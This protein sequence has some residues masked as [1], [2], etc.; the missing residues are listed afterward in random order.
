MAVQYIQ[1]RVTNPGKPSRNS[2]EESA[3]MSYGRPRR[4]LSGRLRNSSRPSSLRR[5]NGRKKAA[6]AVVVPAKRKPGRPKKVALSPAAVAVIEAPKKRK[7]RK[8]RKKAGLLARAK[9]GASRFGRSLRSLVLGAPKK[10]RKGG[11]KGKASRK[12]NP[13]HA[14]RRNALRRVRRSN[15]GFDVKS[16]LIESAVLVGGTIAAIYAVPFIESKLKEL[17]PDTFQGKTLAAV[18]L[19]GAAATV[20]GGHFLQKKYG[21]KI[22]LMPAAYSIATVMALRA[23]KNADILPSDA[24]AGVMSGTMI[25]DRAPNGL[26]YGS[27]MNG[28][29]HGLAYGGMGESPLPAGYSMLGSIFTDS[30]LPGP[31]VAPHNVMQGGMAAVP[32]MC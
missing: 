6:A 27:S 7:S 29:M 10:K 19:L 17:A 28:T 8:P 30:Q 24:I 23:V 14:R 3:S 1:A 32:V 20:V 5:P 21:K 18:Q 31:S 15:P 4:S 2:S 12:A 13:G 26:A 16:A 22:D 11:K 9:R 25:T